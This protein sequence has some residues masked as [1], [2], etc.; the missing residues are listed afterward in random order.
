MAP[1]NPFKPDGAQIKIDLD[2]PHGPYNPGDEAEIL[3][4]LL[5]EKD[6][7][8]D[9][10]WCGL[11]SWEQ[12]TTED[13]DGYSTNWK[14]MDEL[15]AEQVLAENFDI[16]SGAMRTFRMRFWIPKDAYPP[17]KGIYI[18]GGL[19]VQT[20]LELG[21]RRTI[22]QKIELPL[23]VP[24]P[25]EGSPEGEYGVSSRPDAVDML[26]WLPGL[27]FLE[28]G[29]IEGRLTILGREKITAKEV[30]LQL[31]RVEHGHGSRVRTKHS[32]KIESKQV[33]GRTQ[34]SPGRRSEFSFKFNLPQMG[35]PT[36]V[37][38]SA[39]INYIF[40]G[41]LNR[42]WK[43]DYTVDVPIR[44]YASSRAD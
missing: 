29:V 16:A 40:Q 22:D 15:E 2:R 31:L 34:V 24:L 26:L 14:T 7:H 5:G 11:R 43:A 9:R 8:V 27:E 44:I 13:S 35:C 37:T 3:V 38:P 1:I 36:R 6:L 10:F 30:R 42:R 33:A 18:N 41:V 21:L 17:C 20:R 4:T 12:V 32:L 28:G 39:D 25:A 19:Q 23:V